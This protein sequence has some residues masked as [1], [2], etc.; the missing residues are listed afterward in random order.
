MRSPPSR[1]EDRPLPDPEST[2]RAARSVSTTRNPARTVKV[3]VTEV[4]EVEDAV[5]DSVEDVVEEDVEEDE[6][7]SGKPF[8]SFRG[9][10][11]FFSP[12]R[13]AC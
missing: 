8:H 6:V 7:D 13:K 10:V 12:S 4:D 9:S 2:L 11:L 3:E 1:R 5:E